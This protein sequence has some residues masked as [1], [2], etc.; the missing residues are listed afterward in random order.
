MITHNFGRFF[1]FDD[2]VGQSLLSKNYPNLLKVFSYTKI[3]WYAVPG[4]F[5]RYHLLMGCYKWLCLPENTQVFF[6]GDLMP[7][8]MS[9]QLYR[10]Q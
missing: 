2:N 8:F 6:N 1:Y 7:R 4:L 3:F 10:K 5:C 9:R